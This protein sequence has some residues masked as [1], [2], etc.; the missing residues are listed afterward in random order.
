MATSYEEIYG[1]FTAKIT[2][3]S[4]LNLTQDD[5]DKILESLL[6]SSVVKFRRCKKNLSDRDNSLKQFNEDLTDEEQEIIAQL[7]IVEYL[8]PKIVTADLLQQTLSSK[9]FRLYSQANHIKEIKDLRNTM[10]NEA[11]QMMTQYTYFNGNL[12]D[13]L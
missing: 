7:M 10:R 2:D 4:F 1:R 12:D 3:Y 8:T 9:D 13:L 5:L 6:K 11:N